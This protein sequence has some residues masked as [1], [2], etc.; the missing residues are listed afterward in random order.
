MKKELTC[1]ICPNGCTIE[2]ELDTAGKITAVKNAS[3]PKGKAYAEQELTCPQRTIASSVR[4]EGGELPLAS[5]RLTKPIPK[6]R[7]FDAMAQIC[8]ITLRAPVSAG[9][10]VIRHILGY[11]SDVIVTKNIAAI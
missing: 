11:D 9:T 7:I 10:T 2:I 3:C 1:V 6:G 8:K 4:V 5:V